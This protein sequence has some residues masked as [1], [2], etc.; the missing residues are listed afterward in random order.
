M[1][2]YATYAVHPNMIF[3]TGGLMSFGTGIIHRKCSEN[4]INTI[5]EVFKMFK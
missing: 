1:Q 4:N 3:H 2:I 5:I